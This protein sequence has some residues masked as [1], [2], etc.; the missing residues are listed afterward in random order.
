[1]NADP[2]LLPKLVVLSGAEKGKEIVLRAE[3]SVIGRTEEADLVI[4][5]KSISRRHAGIARRDGV[6]VVRDLESKNGLRV[7][8]RDVSEQAL[9]TGDLVMIGAV[10]IKFIDPRELAP[11]PPPDAGASGPASFP[12]AAAPAPFPFLPPAPPAA[13]PGPGFPAA[14]APAD[15]PPPAAAGLGPGSGPAIYTP[16]PKV[17]AEIYAPPPEFFAPQQ[18][19]VQAPVRRTP[20]TRGKVLLYLV[21]F[22]AVGLGLG[23][24]V[25]KTFWPPKAPF[26]EDVK[27]AV[28]EVRLVDLIPHFGA[29]RGARGRLS[30]SRIADAQWDPEL[31]IL[32]VQG[33]ALGQAE[34]VF[35]DP[36]AED[37][38]LGSVGIHVLGGTPRK[39]VDRLAISEDQR[40]IQ[41]QER[42]TEGESLSKA[43]LAEA[44]GKYEEA[45]Y[46]LEGIEDPN[47]V[48]K[49]R[50]KLTDLNAQRDDRF[51]KLKDQ[52]RQKN[53]LKD[54][55][56]ARDALEEI[57]KLYP[58]PE[59]E[60]NQQAK[61][62]IRRILNAER[63]QQNRKKD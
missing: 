16:R 26:K 57:C 47:L 11:V 17:Q 9:R 39:Y 56:G 54:F 45:N 32:R 2:S 20:L 13:G 7:N 58:D 59:N 5:D 29:L 22:G 48:A 62:F 27:L 36:E 63:A 37:R 50:V 3:D 55:P 40:R 1:M 6:W 14:P 24:L 41:A 21:V 42:M 18:P 15:P 46:L 19:A 34:F 43:H 51:R 10:R 35:V 53:R 60:E 8:N 38:V 23:F 4:R 25:Y 30:G 52:Y 28:D 49:A 44:I 12:P 33:R 61:I 31:A